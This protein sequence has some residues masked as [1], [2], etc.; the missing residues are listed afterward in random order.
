MLEVRQIIL[1]QKLARLECTRTS[2]T[3]YF[4]VETIHR[5]NCTVLSY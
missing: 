3:R 2:C 5:I 1:A 4:L